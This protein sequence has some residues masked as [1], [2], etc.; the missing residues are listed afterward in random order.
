MKRLP[1]LTIA[2]ATAALAVPGVAAA[3]KP[4]VL[5]NVGTGVPTVTE[6]QPGVSHVV[7]NDESAKVLHYCQVLKGKPG[8]SKSTV[9]SFD[10]KP[11]DALAGGP[12]K[13]WI[14]T[15]AD[16]NTLYLVHAQYVSGDDYVWTSTDDGTSFKGPVKV[17]GGVNGTNGT[18]SERP[19]LF[20]ANS[21]I[22][23]P[24]TNTGLFVTDA[25]L[26]G[27]NA[28]SEAKANLDQTGLG[29][30]SYNLSLATQGNG[31]LA[32]ADDLE[33]VYSWLAP[34]GGDLS[35]TPAWGPPKLVAAGTDSTM[36]GV[37]TSTYLGYTG[38]T[39]GKRN[40]QVRRWNGAAFGAP[41]TVAKTPG[42]LADL[43]TS[44]SGVP[45][46][47]F[48]ENGT[49]LR[50]ASSANDGKTWK[51]K[52]IAA[53]DEVFFDLVMAHDDDGT[54]LAVWT[55]KGAVVAAD[56]TEVPDPSAPQK[57]TTVTK[58]GRTIGLNVPGGCVVPGKAYKL[59][60]GGQGKG[61]L[62]KV[63]Y[64]FGAQV[65]TD[66]TKPFS[67]SF[68][69]PKKAKAGTSIKA[70]SLNSFATKSSSFTILVSSSVTVCGG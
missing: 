23:F 60:T 40:L 61:K 44:V 5:G 53:S 9:L 68:T 67:A 12:G 14:V 45:G 4:Y 22:A 64:T 57:S 46:V 17:W 38:G 37:G 65:K 66:T 39:S 36:S 16:A 7:W 13:A 32:T 62:V 15:G 59:T 33:H 24:T 48:R 42:Y 70:T 54:G 1:V 55:R 43:Y 56:L 69:V 21:S 10:E 8:C 6:G 31:T 18:D 52:T 3:G 49:G 26:D 58:H 63:R 41:V 29:S 25:K 28:A 35:T 30:R 34:N 11:G 51:T 20:P 19:L 50:Y 27:S 2:A 47:A